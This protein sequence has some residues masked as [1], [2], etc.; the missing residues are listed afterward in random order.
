MEIKELKKLLQEPY[1]NANWKILLT[2]VFTNVDFLAR[3]K[4]IPTTDSRVKE[5][6]QYGTVRL[7]DGKNLALFEL[8]LNDNVNLINNRVGLNELVNKH[9]DQ[10][11]HHG[12]LS[13]FEQGKEDYRFTFTAKN[14]EFDE[15]QGFVNTFTDTK[16]F[17]YI[18][19]ANESCRTAAERFDTLSKIPKKTIE[20]VED[21]FNVEKL[22]KKF[23]KEYIEQFDKMV[24]FLKSKPTYFQAVFNGNEST[25]RN[26][27]KRFMGR[28]VFLKFIQKKGW[29][30]V[31]TS[32]SGWENGD[33]QFLENQFKNFKHKEVFVSQFLNPLFYEALDV[34]DRTNDE[35]QN[36]GYKIPYLSGGLFDNDYPVE[37]RVDFE[38][39]YLTNLF[40]FFERYNFTIDENDLHDKEVGIDPE[41]LGHI[42]ENLLEDNKDKGAFYTPKEIVRYMCQESLK[43]YL[44]THLEKVK[45]WPKSEEKS[46]ELTESIANFVEK[47]ETSA[48]LKFD[49]E[50][51]IALR[52]VKICDPAIGSGAFPMGL[53][54]EI[55]TMM[56]N[57]HEASPDIVG[58]VW[59]MKDEKWQPN[60][61]KENIIKN[62]IYGVDI[63]AGAVDIARLRFWLSLVLEEQEP[64]PLPHLDYKI[65][66]G[67]SL[68]SKLGDTIID[69]DWD[70][71]ERTKGLF[72]SDFLENQKNILN[73]IT[74]KQIKAFDPNSDDEKLSIEIKN[75][76]IDLLINQL[77]L[78]IE[79]TVLHKPPNPADKKFKELNAI[80]LDVQGWKKQIKELEYLKKQK[81]K[82]L[83]FFDWRLDFAEVMN[84]KINEN[85]GFDIVIGNPPYL[86]DK[87]HKEVFRPVMQCQF[88]FKYYKGQMD[89]FYYFFHK[90]I[91]LLKS[92]ANLH[93]IT[94]N[95]FI[96]ANG[97]IKLRKDFK[98]RTSIKKIINFNELRIFETALGQH[99]MITFLTKEFAPKSIAEVYVSNGK[100]LFNLKTIRKFINKELE[101]ANY[102]S[103][104]NENLYETEQNYIRLIANNA[105]ENIN[106]IFYK[107]KLNTYNLSDK[108]F[109]NAG[110]GVTIGK[111]SSKYIIDYPDLDIEAGDGV[112][113]VNHKES[114]FIEKD[115]LKPFIKN[116]DIEHYFYNLNEDK[117]IY[118]TRLDN[119]DDFNETKKHLLKFIKILKDQVISYEEKF[120]WY[121]LNRPRTRDIFDDT[122][123]IVLPYRAKNNYFAYSNEP[124]Y[125]SRD[126][127]Y[128]RKKEKSQNIKSLLALLN[129]KLI[130]F[131][132]YHKGKRKG[133]IL[134]MVQTPIS[135]I[136]IP[137]FNLKTE[138]IL[139]ETINLI[140]SE[141]KNSQKICN[142]KSNIDNLVYKI[143]NLT[144]E[145][146]LIIEPELEERLSEAEYN[147][148]VI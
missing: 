24:D 42:F 22:S 71:D 112:F 21:A 32:E 135:E 76:K 117:L 141:R 69:I 6:K 83:Q 67:N 81:D 62:S 44:K 131:W 15:E 115:I 14:T 8:T 111:L 50:I 142:F 80:W 118:L 107:I 147:A 121:A 129:S 86:G 30:G 2:H 102:Y 126:V 55:F 145:E 33:F 134:E 40:D 113:V 72:E 4:I 95:Y 116:S 89:L 11:N 26:Y 78:L 136:P 87:G 74:E 105:T 148:L 66:V 47:K 60:V 43:E 20:E 85:A 91:D 7:S 65:V 139:E 122:D 23:F 51:A 29:L 108:F 17:T 120:P 13:I 31:P 52:D 133:E 53:L 18:L 54:N 39:K 46:R 25:A 88:G 138:K 84:P 106:E 10:Y 79:N 12:I 57:L 5:L 48:L 140:L 130:Y 143:Y 90:G 49:R 93:F 92:K 38:V 127:L 41:M 27:V 59:N 77:S 35:F 104:K 119:I 103:E 132:L 9:I 19:G 144:F 110:I 125:G 99:N 123:K 82:D 70:A 96:T 137:K 37:N 98:E 61:V 1:S 146:A 64:K 97:A 68:V 63:E 28:L 101:T 3:P 75:L 100:Q 16:R 56:K 45:L 58:K 73:K 94:T 124:V 109:I 36:R 114:K 34:G 128:I